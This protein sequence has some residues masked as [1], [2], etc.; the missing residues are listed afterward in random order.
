MDIYSK[1]FTVTLN[2]VGENNCLTNKGIL[3]MF[4]EIGC[5]HCATVGL[6]LNNVKDTGLFWIILNWKLQVF[7]RPTWNTSL[8]VN[9]W[10]R[11]HNELYFYRDFEMF[12]EQNNLIAI[13]TSKWVL[14]DF[15]KNGIFKVTDDF[16]SRYCTDFDKC[17]FTS[18]MEEKFKEPKNHKFVSNYTIQKRD[19]DANHHVNNLNYLDFAYEIVSENFNNVEIMYKREVKLGETLELFYYEENNS[20]FVTMKNK[21]TNKLCCIVKLY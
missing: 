14:Y 12:D 1:N 18:P 2:D 15:K 19:I 7:S 21:D 8:K 5:M 4:Q 9:T 6:G 17:V 16:N 3:R 20:A 11:K 13:A 10:S